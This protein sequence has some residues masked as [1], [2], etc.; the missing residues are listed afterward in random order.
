MSLKDHSHCSVVK[1]LQ[2][3]AR[4]AVGRSERGCGTTGERRQWLGQEWA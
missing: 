4:V 2:H 3:E 1:R